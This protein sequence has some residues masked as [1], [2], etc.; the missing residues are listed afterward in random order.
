VIKHQP[1]ELKDK[2]LYGSIFCIGAILFVS[3]IVDTIEGL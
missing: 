1:L 3:E 2:I